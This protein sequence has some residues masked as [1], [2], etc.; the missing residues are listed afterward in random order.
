MP[1]VLNELNLKDIQAILEGLSVYYREKNYNPAF[2][3]RLVEQIKSLLGRDTTT[4]VQLQM[5][6]SLFKSFLA[7]RYHNPEEIF[8]LLTQK[9]IQV[10]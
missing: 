5:L 3:Q 4:N 8:T 10:L 1:R 7:I 9:V 2:S 6:H